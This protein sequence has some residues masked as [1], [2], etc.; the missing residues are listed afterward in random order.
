M[1]AEDI[2][3]YLA[4]FK[5]DDRLSVWHIALLVTILY[6]GCV[7]GQRQF[8]NVSRSNLMIISHIRT[9]PTY[10]KYFNELQYLGYIKYYPSYKPGYKSSVQFLIEP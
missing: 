4:I 2:I 7:Q 6:L 5:K 10:H 9:L 1:T 8:I 3:K